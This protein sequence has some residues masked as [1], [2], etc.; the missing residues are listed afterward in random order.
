MSNYYSCLYVVMCDDTCEL[1]IFPGVV[2]VFQSERKAEAYIAK[3]NAESA[4]KL[5][6]IDTSFLNELED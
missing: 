4:R 1:E 6:Y 2:A 5:Y 3:M